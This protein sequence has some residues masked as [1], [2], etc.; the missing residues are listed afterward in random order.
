MS[1]KKKTDN[2]QNNK[3]NTKLSN[4][5]KKNFEIIGF[6]SSI[7][8]LVFLLLI[9]FFNT[10]VKSSDKSIMKQ[11][12]NAYTSKETK[13]IFYHNTNE[14]D[15]NYTLNFI[16]EV[17]MRDV[18]KEYKI[19]YIDIDT[20]KLSENNKKDIENKLGISGVTPAVIVVNNR[21]VTGVSD[22]YIE[23]HNLFKLLRITKLIGEDDTY[24]KIS[25][26]KFINYDEYKK[27]L[28]D[29]KINVIIVGK[30][31]CKYCMSVKPIL[32]NIS[33]AYKKEF[34]YLDLS[35][36]KSDEVQ[37]FFD[38]IQKKG[39]EE[40]DLKNSQIFNTPT[41]LITKEGKIKA[42]LSGAHELNE[43]IEF[44]KKNK[45]IE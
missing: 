39:Y 10:K 40:E 13:L 41:V 1:N 16:E 8:L 34:K 29:K 20:S 5:Q 32:N 30:A 37:Q 43:Y 19:D 17:Y 35:D 22:G 12:N 2:K 21:T 26:L 11:F 36:L 18:K 45:A 27:E 42:Y 24:S 9:I 3:K 25:N 44:F 31:G 28:K 23:S 6:I 15:D 4:K 14:E 38:D 33:K 7:L